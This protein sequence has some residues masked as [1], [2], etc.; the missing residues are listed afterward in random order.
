MASNLL[1]CEFQVDLW[2]V[3]IDSTLTLVFDASARL[4][5]NYLL[6]KGVLHYLHQI[7]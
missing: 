1:T 6:P 7:C 4:N 5:S 2:S 3:R